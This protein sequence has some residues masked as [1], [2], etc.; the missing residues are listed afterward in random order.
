MADAAASAAPA[1]PAAPAE[2]TYVFGVDM[3]CGGC[4]RAVENVLKKLE[5]VK[6]FKVS[7]ENK[8]A[9]VVTD[10]SLSF[11][12]VLEKIRGAGKTVTS[13]KAD[14]VPQSIPLPAK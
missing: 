9:T 14:G 7:H 5:G 3:P 11:E 8:N 10:A 2:H 4:S 1:A 12:Q 6:S 13:G